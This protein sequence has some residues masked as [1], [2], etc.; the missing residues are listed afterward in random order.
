MEDGV[1]TSCD[2]R[3]FKVWQGI[4]WWGDWCPDCGGAPEVLT[5]APP[6]MA[7]DGDEV[8][9]ESCHRKGCAVCVDIDEA[10]VEWDD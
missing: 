2:D 4:E 6:G 3:G 8:R 9:C 1:F 10:Y 7:C 5:N